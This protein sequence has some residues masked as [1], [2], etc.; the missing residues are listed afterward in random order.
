MLII[1][2]LILVTTPI[3]NTQDITLRALECLKNAQSII[4]EDTREIKKLL[5]LLGVSGPKKFYTFNDHKE[6]FNWQMIEHEEALFVS[7]AG[8]P[9]VSDPAYPLI[10]SAKKNNIIIDSCSGISALITALELS[11][12]PPIPFLFHGFLQ[13]EKGKKK[14]QIQKLK[15]V[16]GSH[17]FFEAP[18]RIKETLLVLKDIMPEVDVFVG[19]ELTKTF[20]TLYHFKAKEVESVIQ[21]AFIEKGELVV[22][23]HIQEEIDF[24]LE[25]VQKLVADYLE[26]PHKKT[27]AKIL[28]YFSKSEVKDIYSLL[29]NRD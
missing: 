4:A 22:G 12:L 20:Q 21:D 19:R 10:L 25:E 17:F 9:I 13:R 23:F 2:K 7:D 5:T 29:G 8:S 14:T 24:D 28:S 26:R 1:K 18:H 15:Q 11:Q 3:G 6:D 27:L 16:K